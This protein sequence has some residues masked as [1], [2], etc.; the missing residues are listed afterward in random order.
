MATATLTVTTSYASVLSGAKEINLQNITT[1]NIEYIVAA[2]GPAAGDVGHR[3]TPG[4]LHPVTIPTGQN[5]YVRN[6]SLSANA[7]IVYSDATRT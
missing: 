6:K 5:L 2:S 4:E 3:L 7:T 1:H